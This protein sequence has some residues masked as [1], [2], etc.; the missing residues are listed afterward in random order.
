MKPQVRMPASARPATKIAPASA[1]QP[2]PGMRATARASAA[3]VT[4]EKRRHFAVATLFRHPDRRAWA[5]TAAQQGLGGR[6]VV[7]GGRD[8]E[9]RPAAAVGLVHPLAELQ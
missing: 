1:Y 2:T 7:L 5:G 9:G 4:L 6:H 3:A 8:H